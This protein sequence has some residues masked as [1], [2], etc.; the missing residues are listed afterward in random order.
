[1]SSS[2]FLTFNP[3]LQD[4]SYTT[5]LEAKNVD[6]DLEVESMPLQSD[7]TVWEQLESNTNKDYTDSTKPIYHFDSVMGF[8]RVWQA[9]P[10]PSQLM[11]SHRMIRKN[12]DGED[13]L[14][15]ALM[16][17]RDNIKPM[18]EDPVNSN[19][20]HY[21]IRYQL[22][23]D[24]ESQARV[25]EHW[26][27]LVL[28]MIGSS[29][30]PAGMITGVRLVDKLHTARGAFLR[31]EIW[32]TEMENPDAKK[33]LRQSIEEIMTTRHDSTIDPY[34]FQWVVKKHSRTGK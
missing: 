19:G 26:N 32:F 30:E 16:I 21:E 12:N 20:G 31:I 1:M 28:G 24:E 11:R 8:W 18:W 17:F 15:D 13:Q 3:D 22:A 25:D 34:A 7:W 14:V 27:N 6:D 4:I 29:I 33:V 2:V 10:Q 5:E 9:L 23:K